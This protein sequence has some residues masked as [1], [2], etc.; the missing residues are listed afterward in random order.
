MNINEKLQKIEHTRRMVGTGDYMF[1]D[2]KWLIKTIK[3]L[4][5]ENER[6]N[7]T[8]ESIRE[9]NGCKSDQIIT[10]QKRIEELEGYVQ[11]ASQDPIEY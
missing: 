3:Q 1:A 7:V 6:L 11:M 2:V 5:E 8:V 9:L 10:Q 4:Q